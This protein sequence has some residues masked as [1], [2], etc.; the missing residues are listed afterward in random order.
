MIEVDNEKIGLQF[1]YCFFRRKE[2]G[3]CLRVNY[4]LTEIGSLAG[5]ELTRQRNIENAS[6][7]R[8]IS[9]EQKIGRHKKS[10]F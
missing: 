1:R 10:N 2:E 7:T 3:R 9:K 8:E 6:M 4:A 5:A